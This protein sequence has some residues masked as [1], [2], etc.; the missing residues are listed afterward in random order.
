M[1]SCAESRLEH[2]H[3]STINYH[4]S[5]E[6]AIICQKP[7]LLR[8]FHPRDPRSMID[9]LSSSKTWNHLFIFSPNLVLMFALP[10]DSWNQLYSKL[11]SWIQLHDF[12]ISTL[13]NHSRVRDHLRT[14]RILTSST[15]MGSRPNCS[16]AS[17]R[18]RDHYDTLWWWTSAA[19]RL[20]SIPTTIQ[21]Y[22][23]CYP[24]AGRRAYI[25]TPLLPLNYTYPPRIPGPA[26]LESLAS[27]ESRV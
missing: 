20:S 1:S 6:H 18:A 15:N 11:I 5:S 17:T 9:A 22:P 21:L 16:F 13:W 24:R 8:A 27:P 3:Q 4:L 25:H 7:V 10:H 12:I 19:P 2:R 26:G 14:A 23:F